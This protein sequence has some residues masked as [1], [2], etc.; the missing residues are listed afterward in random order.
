MIYEHI[1]EG[2]GSVWRVNHENDKS[3]HTTGTLVLLNAY[4]PNQNPKVDRPL[5]PSRVGSTFASEL[6]ETWSKR[7]TELLMP[8]IGLE[9]F[10]T[11]KRN[12]LEKPL[13]EYI[14]RLAY[15]IDMMAISLRTATVLPS[16]TK[17]P[18]LTISTWMLCEATWRVFSS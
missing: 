15:H 5:Q 11:S 8:M 2:S 10:L 13:A 12:F 7:H 6:G 9:T 3:R 16:P 14:Q 4:K 18:Q 1:A 17:S